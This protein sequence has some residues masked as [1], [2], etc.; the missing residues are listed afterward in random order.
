MAATCCVLFQL[1][2]CL[3]NGEFY[4][5]FV[6]CAEC[7]RTDVLHVD[8]RLKQEAD[9]EETVTYDRTFISLTTAYTPGPEKS[10]T[11]FSTITLANPCRFF[12]FCTTGNR[13]EYS[14]S[15]CNLLT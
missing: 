14:T 5:N 1:T 7:S 15:T 10:A 4:S 3:D 8:N 12:T 11:L 9:D 13:N 2:V 6:G